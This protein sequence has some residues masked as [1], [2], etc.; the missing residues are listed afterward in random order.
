MNNTVN[1]IITYVTTEHRSA[2]HRQDPDVLGT[3]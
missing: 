3:V 2:S 1:I